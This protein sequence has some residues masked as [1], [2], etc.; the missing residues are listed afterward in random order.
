MNMKIEKKINVMFLVGSL[1]TGGIEN[2]VVLLANALNKSLFNVAICCLSKPGGSFLNFID[3]NSIKLIFLNF[4]TRYFFLGLYK[5]VRVLKNNKIQIIHTHGYES[6]FW[7]RLAAW[8]IKTPIIIVHEHG[9]TLWKK[10]R[11]L[12]FER[13][14]GKYTDLRIAVSKDVMQLRIKMEKT[15]KKKIILIPNGV[16]VFNNQIINVDKIKNELNLDK[17]KFII[18][19]VGRLVEA[20]AYHVLID[21][22]EKIKSEIRNSCLIIIGDGYLKK[23]LR[24]YV[25]YKFIKEDVYFLG[26]RKDVNTT[27][28]I[29]NVFVLSSIREGLPVSMLEAMAAKIPVVCTNVGGIPDVIQNGKN[30]LLVT[31]NDASKL[32]EK[33]IF[34]L[35][36]KKER[37]LLIKNALNSI[38]EK[39]SIESVTSKIED[40]YIRLAKRKRVINCPVLY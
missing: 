23:Q 26:E 6:G 33:I 17:Y 28:K 11:H 7:G 22:F 29:F 36:N 4:K 35:T 31:I 38:N 19:T 39:Y 15:P 9:K 25:N 3:H 30:G 32:A 24:E 8:F 18:G 1:N 13:F 12:L 16:K 37:D 10:R 5:L 2:Q 21:A 34:V 14:A 27:I 20:K 40:L